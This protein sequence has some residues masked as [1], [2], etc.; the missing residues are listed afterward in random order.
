MTGL[1]IMAGI[2]AAGALASAAATVAAGRQQAQTGKIN[3]QLANQSASAEQQEAAAA[4]RVKREQTER[5]LSR[6][7]ALS[8]MSGGGADDPSVIKL[9]TDIGTEGEYQARAISAL[10]GTRAGQLRAAGQ[11]AAQQGR[12]AH[13]G[14]YLSAAGTIG[15][16]AG[17]L[18]DRMN[19]GRAPGTYPTTPQIATPTFNPLL[20]YPGSRLGVTYG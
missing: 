14:S 19:F 9:G 7:Q 10:G 1:E 2:S 15:Q 4:A 3:Q 8:A 6:L 13:A 20:T 18:Y 16:A 12:A 11:L 17:T 5:L